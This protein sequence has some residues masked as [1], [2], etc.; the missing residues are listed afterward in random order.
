MNHVESV[1]QLLASPS[2][3]VTCDGLKPI[4]RTILIGESNVRI[5]FDIADGS[6]FSLATANILES[7]IDVNT[8][9]V[10]DTNGQFHTIKFYKPATI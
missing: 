2:V 4:K 1:L 10:Y 3:V 5:S 8:I 9:S 7:K 6:F